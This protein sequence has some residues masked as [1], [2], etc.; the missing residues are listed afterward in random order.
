M[1]PHLNPSKISYYISDDF[2][3]GL[4][5][6]FTDWQVDARLITD[7]EVRQS[8]E[9]LLIREARILDEVRLEDWLALFVPECVYW[10]PGTPDQGDPRS[11]VA[12]AF[13]DRR[14]LEDRVYRLRLSHAWSQRPVSRTVR[15]ITNIET[16]S[17]D[18]ED[19]VM[20]RSNFLISEFWTD[21]T[22]Y[23]SGWCGHRLKRNK[24]GW[25]ILVKQINLINCDQN[26]RNPSIIL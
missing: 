21:D 19:V 10:V 5:D 7:S 26:I 18:D 6:D 9:A 14:R 12:I 11:E 13:D 22:R 20:V 1:G 24:N 25:D 15:H 4:I 8:A 17:T 2:Y 16:F 23:W 3:R